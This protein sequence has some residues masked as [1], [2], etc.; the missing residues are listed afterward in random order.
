MIDQL[1]LYKLTNKLYHLESDIDEDLVLNILNNK[2]FYGYEKMDILHITYLGIRQKNTNQSNKE[3]Y[4]KCSAI[5]N[6]LNEISQYTYTE[7]ELRKITLLY[8]LRMRNFEQTSFEDVKEYIKMIESI[9]VDDISTLLPSMQFLNEE[10]RME[11]LALYSF[12]GDIYE[13]YESSLM[14]HLVI[15]EEN[16]KLRQSLANII[17]VI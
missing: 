16:E 14:E 12:S 7:Q 8:F 6:R 4:K 2:D 3:I 5:I 11:L 9:I 1:K 10:L 17:K 13:D 15:A